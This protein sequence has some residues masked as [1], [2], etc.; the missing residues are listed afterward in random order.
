MTRI[1]HIIP[2]LR[3]GG[4]ERLCFDSDIRFVVKPKSPNNRKVNL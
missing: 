2:Q 4:A 3:K 1:L